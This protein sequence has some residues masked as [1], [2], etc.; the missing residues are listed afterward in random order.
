MDYA[1]HNIIMYVSY[2]LGGKHLQNGTLLCINVSRKLKIKFIRILKVIILI[3][4]LLN[5]VAFSSVWSLKIFKFFH[6]RG[7]IFHNLKKIILPFCFTKN[8]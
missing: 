8:M 5:I 1:A 6:L 3:G 2:G 7:K 4:L